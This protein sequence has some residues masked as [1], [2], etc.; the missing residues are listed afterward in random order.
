VSG[1]PA[2]SGYFDSPWPCEDGGPRRLASP[3]GSPGLGLRDGETLRAT[4]RRTTLSTMTVLGAPGEVFL[5]LHSALRARLGLPTRARVERIDPQ[6]L[7][8]LR[9]S[10]PL[11]GG[12]MWPGGLAVLR[13]GALAVVY[14][15]WTHRLDR[16]CMLLAS[17]EL[18]EP[19]P[20][21]GFVALDD[22]VLVTKNLSRTRRARFTVLDPVTLAP[23][24]DDVVLDEPSVAR[25]SA[26]GDTVYAIGLRTAV[27][28]HWDRAARRLRPD[29]G[30]RVDYA[31]DAGCTHGWDAVIDGTHAWFMDN[32]EHRYLTTMVGAGVGRA[33]NRLVRVSLSDPRDRVAIEVSGLPAGSVT[34]PPLVDPR[35]RVVVGFDSANRVLRAWRIDT[36]GALVPLWSKRRFGCAS[37]G[38]LYAD[39]GELVVNDWR[40]VGEDVVVLDVVTGAERGRVRVG[41]FTQGVVFPSPGW[42]RDLY[43]STMSV[44][45]RIRVDAARGAP[46][47]AA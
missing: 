37:H 2:G 35:R 34:N 6:T 10:A 11:R 46:M 38:L 20:Y 25:L 47:A 21:N 31:G 23:A 19:E 39:T 24:C 33:A 1:A 40:R 26:C 5:L 27:R 41:G 4:I 30:W 42:G 36:D 43:W 22:G 3:H 16:D 17:R 44:L 28:L 45:A 8:P 12:P 9:R 14:G 29:P 15:R 7:R 32:G 13:D 18:P